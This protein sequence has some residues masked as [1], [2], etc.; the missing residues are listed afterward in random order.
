MDN[1]ILGPGMTYDE[2]LDNPGL[3]LQLPPQYEGLR[4]EL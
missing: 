4:T 3:D 2:T 1:K